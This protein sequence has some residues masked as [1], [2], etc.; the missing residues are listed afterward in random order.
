MNDPSFK[1]CA[2]PLYLTVIIYDNTKLKGFVL[3][4][5]FRKEH[6]E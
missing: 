3:E 6:N 5:K 1:F 4:K 2:T